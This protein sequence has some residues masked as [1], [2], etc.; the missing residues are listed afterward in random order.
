[1]K[2]NSKILVMALVAIIFMSAFS[3]VN[4]GA[5]YQADL[6]QFLAKQSHY[7]CGRNYTATAEQAK[8]IEEYLMGANAKDF[9]DAK[10]TTAL[11]KLNE[12]I[13]AL[14]ATGAT[15]LSDVPK[16]IQAKALNLVQEAA[17]QVDVELKVDLN[18]NRVEAVNKDNGKSLMS[19]NYVTDD[20]GNLAVASGTTQKAPSMKTFDVNGASPL[21][22]RFDKDYSYFTN[23]G[24]V[25]VDFNLVDSSNY[26]S[27]SGSTIIELK[28][29]YMKKLGTGVHTLTVAFSDGTQISEG[30]EVVGSTG[31]V[32]GGA[33]PAPA[34]NAA[35][36]GKAF[37]YTGNNYAA[38]IALSL[39]AVVAVS[40]V[41]VKKV[42][43]K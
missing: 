37:A 26:I 40:T 41:F 17:A 21:I 16:D 34:G 39:V 1:M 24:R 6:W 33:A 4:A 9:S 43:A 19:F 30:F 38:Y 42:Y 3:F 20:S 32:G 35:T 10:T 25:Y 15:K 14:N 18:S 22:F 23:G 8:I 11:A 12:A 28:P 2:T 36:T 13:N 7:I 31:A 5:G 27:K 29:E